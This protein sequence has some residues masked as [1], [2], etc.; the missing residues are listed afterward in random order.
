MTTPTGSLTLAPAAQVQYDA[1][2]IFASSSNQGGLGTLVITFTDTS[3][4]APINLNAQDWFNVTTNNALNSLGRANLNSD[5]VEATT[6]SN[7]RIYQ[8]TI[9]MVALG[10]NN[11]NV[12]S[13]S[14][15]KPAVGGAA[16]NTI[17]MGISGW[18]RCCSSIRWLRRD[19]TAGGGERV[20]AV[21]GL[22]VI[23]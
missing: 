19:G 22:R 12:Q 7:P 21:L 14:F 1:M 10:L 18:R 13:I 2:A 6:G 17:V 15:T 11:R 20:G 16:Q 4:S 5:T 9:D 3:T 23:V 8:T